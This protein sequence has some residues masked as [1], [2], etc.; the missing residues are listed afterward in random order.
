MLYLQD[1]TIRPFPG[2]VNFVPAFAYHFC[3]GLP[4]TLPEPGNGLI[5]R[6]VTY[7]WE[8][9]LKGCMIPS[10][11][12]GAD[13]RAFHPTFQNDL[14]GISYIPCKAFSRNTFRFLTRRK[15]SRQGVDGCDGDHGSPHRA[16]DCALASSSTQSP[17]GPGRHKSCSPVTR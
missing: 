13:V 2:L 12:P 15:E 3:L 8:V 5:E 16:A 17:P 6:H 1:S 11:R 10:A 14:P 7:V 9:V 4:A